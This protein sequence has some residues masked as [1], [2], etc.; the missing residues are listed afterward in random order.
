ADRL[1]HG[2]DLQLRQVALRRLAR[3][4]LG[5]RALSAHPGRRAGPD[6]APARAEPI[7]TAD[8]EKLEVRGLDAWFGGIRAL[9]GISLGVPARSV[10]AI[11]GPS[12]CGKSTFVRCLN[13]MHELTP[14][15]RSSGQVLLDGGDVYTLDPVQLRRRAG[16]VF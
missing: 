14:G 13:R 10:L 1:A 9:K 12:G 7:V 6:R 8:G 15:A 11:I 3:Q 5:R 4:G 2:A 16:M